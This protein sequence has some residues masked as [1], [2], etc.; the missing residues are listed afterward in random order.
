MGERHARHSSR[1]ICETVTHNVK[2][3]ETN[4]SS[5]PAFTGIHL[6]PAS[7][8]GLVHLIEQA[9]VPLGIHMPFS[10]SENHTR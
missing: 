5:I 2:V 8:V 6:Q 4:F 10:A 3:K 9:L 7:F 1:D